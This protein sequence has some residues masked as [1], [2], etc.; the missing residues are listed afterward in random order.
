M[1]VVDEENRKSATAGVKISAAM[2]KLHKKI[3]VEEYIQ[4]IEFNI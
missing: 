3:E 4:N 1:E 2:D